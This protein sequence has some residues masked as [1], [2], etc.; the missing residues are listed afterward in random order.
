MDEHEI[1]WALS[2]VVPAMEQRFTIDTS[3]GGLVLDGEDA[4]LVQETVKRILLK[5]QR[6]LKGGK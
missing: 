3:Y 4:K 6:K 1:S 2:R 5:K